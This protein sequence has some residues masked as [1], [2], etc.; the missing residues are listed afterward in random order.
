MAGDLS[1]HDRMNLLA[2]FAPAEVIE[3]SSQPAGSGRSQPEGRFHLWGKMDGT[4]VDV[5]VDWGGVF[6]A[7]R[8]AAMAM[9]PPGEA[10]P[11][12]EVIAAAVRSTLGLEA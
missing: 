4:P 6:L 5:C 8:I 1:K 11:A 7:P 12:P 10:A 3:D 2:R 9:T